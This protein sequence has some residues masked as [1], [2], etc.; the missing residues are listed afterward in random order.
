M[1]LSS[2][3]GKTAHIEIT[4]RCRLS[5]S[6]CNRTFLLNNKDLNFKPSNDIDF[7]I[8]EKYANSNFERYL[9]CGSRGDPI[10]HPKF[11]EIIKIL[12]FKD[13]KLHIHTNGSGKKIEWWK[14]LF[15]I[16]DSDDIIW[17]AI[18][19]MADTCHNYRVNF[20]SDDFNQAMNIMKIARHE[21]E[22]NPIWVFIPFS[23]N[24]HQIEDA[25]N[26]A[27]KLDIMFCLRKS[28]RWFIKEDPLLPEDRNLISKQT[29]DL[30]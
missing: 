20:T 16:L 8:I 11:L 6:K 29:Q 10:Y 24:E 12:K 26:L 1:M 25:K 7:K 15:S 30:I 13:K 17:F 27:Y 3:I 21:Y 5:C 18:D 9:L 4:N 23:F 14:K 19:G 2:F 22:L 28:A